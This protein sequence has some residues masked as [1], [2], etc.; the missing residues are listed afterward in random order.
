MAEYSSSDANVER[1]ETVESVSVYP[2]KECAEMF[3][4]ENNISI[5][6][7]ISEEVRE[8]FMKSLNID[9][10]QCDVISCKVLV[11]SVTRTYNS[12]KCLL[13]MS[14]EGKYG[15]TNIVKLLMNYCPM[16]QEKKR[17]RKKEKEIVAAEQYLKRISKKHNDVSPLELLSIR[18]GVFYVPAL[19]GF[20]TVN[21]MARHLWNARA[22]L[23][24]GIFCLE[25]Q[26]Q[27]SCLKQPQASS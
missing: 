16:Q 22:C 26:L 5:N 8:S 10:N 23:Q 24:N 2:M 18:N 21:F 12:L 6:G 25:L 17:K 9:K 15:K 13:C 27:K 4:C 20:D 19:T 3:K 14:Y 1:F 7:D 11:S